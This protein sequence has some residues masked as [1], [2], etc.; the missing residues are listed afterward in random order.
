M[1]R[2]ENQDWV[3]FTV[4][5]PVLRGSGTAD[6]EVVVASNPDIGGQGLIRYLYLNANDADSLELG[7]RHPTTSDYVLGV[8]FTAQAGDTDREYTG[9]Y[10]LKGP[11]GYDVVVVG[12]DAGAGPFTA[13][14]L[15]SGGFTRD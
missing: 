7:F 1:L 9:S 13:H 3:P 11:A 12:K 2:E 14:A 5:V 15:V 4:Q 8:R 6:V 10:V